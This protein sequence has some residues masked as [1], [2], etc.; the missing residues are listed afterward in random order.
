MAAIFSVY[1]FRDLK[2]WQTNWGTPLVLISFLIISI[3]AFFLFYYWSQ[4]AV[5]SIFLPD[6]K[7]TI[8]VIVG[9]ERSQ[10]AKAQFSDQDTDED[11]LH[12]IG[13]RDEDIRKLWTQNSIN[14]SRLY[15]AGSYFLLLLCLT[16]LFSIGVLKLCISEQ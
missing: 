5:R 2:I 9:T 16:A 11:L 6:Q 4:A 14:R 1:F 3:I 7:K 13:Y 12:D 10:F 8:Y 15:V